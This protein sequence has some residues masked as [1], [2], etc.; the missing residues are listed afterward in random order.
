MCTASLDPTNPNS[1]LRRNWSLLGDNRSGEE[2]KAEHF[3]NS[4]ADPTENGKVYF[5]T[6]ADQHRYLDDKAAAEAAQQTKETLAAR[7]SYQ[8]Q[9]DAISADARSIR[10]R[11][12][13][14]LGYS[15]YFLR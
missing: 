12:A 11:Y 13:Q 9:F 6:E 8:T 5:G 2:K 7:A 3:A 1:T 15:P 10:Q 14:S 4:Y